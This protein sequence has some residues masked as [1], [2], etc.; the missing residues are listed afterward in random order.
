MFRNILV[1]I[2]SSPTAQRALSEAVDLAQAL[3][4]RLTII[5]VAPE[6]PG[7]AY[8]AGIDAE[9][10]E[11]EAE[12]QTEEILHVAA[13]SIPDD[14]QVTTVHLLAE[15]GARATMTLEELLPRSF[16]PEYLP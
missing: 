7:Y 15:K 5:C 1:A 4:S 11:H 8:R 16:G 3:N 6:V 14:L 12:A 13:D 10:L 9:K 2:D